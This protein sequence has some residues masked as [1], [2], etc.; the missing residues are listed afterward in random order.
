MIDAYLFDMDGTLVNFP[1]LVK[2][3]W[4]QTFLKYH[5]EKVVSEQDILTIMGHT[6]QEIGKMIF[7]E[8]KVSESFERIKIASEEEVSYIL[9]HGT[10]EDLFIPNEKFL[11]RLSKK[12]Q[13]FIIS[14][15]MSGYIETF[16]QI[17]GYG[18]YFID[19][20][21]NQNGLSKAENIMHMVKKYHLKNPYYIGDTIMDYQACQEAKVSF[22]HAAYGYG[23]VTCE[24]S[25]KT[26]KELL[27]W[28]KKYEKE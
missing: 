7:P 15:C 2:E 1:R 22:I 9:E 19:F 16:Y 3:S 11:K 27:Y 26:L 25:I 13:L 6:T 4:N 23:K 18:K 24:H 5:W 8:L 21:N 12:Y 10:K 20:A 17:S 28:E 14:N